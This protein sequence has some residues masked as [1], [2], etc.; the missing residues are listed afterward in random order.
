[1]VAIKT[2]N[3]QPLTC[4]LLTPSPLP[5][6]ILVPQGAEYN[7]V[8]RGLSRVKSLKPLVVPIPVGSKPVIQYL[9]KWQ[10]MADFLTAKSSGILI[11]GLGGSL[12]PKLAI[13]DIVLYNAC[14]YPSIGSNSELRSFDSELTTLLHHQLGE[15]VPLVRGLTSDRV[16]CSAEEKCHVGQLYDT[17]IVDMEG[18][19]ALEVLSRAGV[20]V[21][22]L[23]VISDDSH[24]DLPNLNSVL[25]PN[26]SLQPLPLAIEMIR[27]PIAAT[28]LIRGAMYGLRVLQNVT[29]RLFS[30]Y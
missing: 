28:R 16:I 11:M 14:V 9:E 13:G 29:T 3:L 7:A 18:F 2:S 21:A 24:H 19:A 15:Q 26:G 8:C 10:Q 25:S 23:R 6:T 4:N 17:Q 12:S 5:Q 22:M 20:A 1:M 30:Q 27:Q